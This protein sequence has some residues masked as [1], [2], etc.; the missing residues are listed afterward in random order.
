MTISHSSRQSFFISGDCRGLEL[1]TEREAQ[2]AVSPF[3]GAQGPAGERGR[4]R[5]P[6]QCGIFLFLRRRRRRRRRRR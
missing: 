4:A 3:W 1:L 5:P 6:W 2:R